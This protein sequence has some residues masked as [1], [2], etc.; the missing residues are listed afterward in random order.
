[1]ED[2]FREAE[3]KL[4]EIFGNEE[5]R[6]EFFSNPIEK[7][8]ESGIIIPPEKEAA[9][10]LFFKN[11]STKGELFSMNMRDVEITPVIEPIGPKPD[12]GVGIGVHF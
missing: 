9:V 6:N 11:C 5:S 7:L 3:R 4:N 12:P 8:S 2:N 10:R 1:M